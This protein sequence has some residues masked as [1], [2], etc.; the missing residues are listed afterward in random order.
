MCVRVRACCLICGS[1]DEPRFPF[2]LG[3][4]LPSLL[5]ALINQVLIR[6]SGTGRGWKGVPDFYSLPQCLL[7][8]KGKFKSINQLERKESWIPN[9]VQLMPTTYNSAPDHD[10]ICVSVLTV[11]SAY[12]ATGV[13]GTWMALS[14]SLH[15]LELQFLRL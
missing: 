9:L 8:W 10:T 15:Y 4:S 11:G 12:G 5:P 14:R 1:G 7:N 3:S 13:A 2:L 6:D